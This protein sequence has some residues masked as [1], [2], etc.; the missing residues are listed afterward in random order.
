MSCK[1]KKGEYMVTLKELRGILEVT[2]CI[3]IVDE[4]ERIWARTEIDWD[5]DH[6]LHKVY[7]LEEGSDYVIKRK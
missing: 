3:G 7:S 1:V 4:L 2:A 6:I 5:I